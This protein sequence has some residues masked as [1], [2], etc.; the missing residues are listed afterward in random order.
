[1]RWAE[2]DEFRAVVRTGRQAISPWCAMQ[3]PE[4]ATLGP[5]PLTWAPG[6]A[7]ALPPAAVPSA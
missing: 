1:M 4:L 3:L 5:N 6:D 7:A 2:W